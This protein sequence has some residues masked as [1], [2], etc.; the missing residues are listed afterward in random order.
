MARHNLL[1]VDGDARNRRVLE[2]SLRKA[3]FSITPAESA[4]EALEFLEHA[5]PDL[6]ISDT[7]LPGDDGFAFCTR[8][9]DNDRWA[10]IPF[11]FLTSGKAIEDKVRGLELGVDDYLTK[12]IYIKEITTRVA[13]LLQRKQRERLER[14]DARTKFSGQLADM[15]VVDLLQTLEISRKSGTIRLSTDLGDATLWFTDGAVIDAEMGR[16]QG[17][18]AVYR[19]LGI[20]DGLFEVEFKA[21]N[22]SQVIT[23]STQALLME[24]MRRVDEWSRLL[25]Q[26][27]PLETALTVDSEQIGERSGVESVDSEQLRFLR[28]FDGRRS[29]LEVVDESGQDDIEAL[30]TISQFFFEGVLALTSGVSRDKTPSPS[31]AASLKL[32]AWAAPVRLSGAEVPPPAEPETPPEDASESATPE[33]PPPPSY[34]A[35]FPQLD[36]EPAAEQ[37][38][39]V[40]GIPEDS[41]P[42]PAFGNSLV[43]LSEEESGPVVE[44]LSQRLDQIERGEKDVFNGPPPDGD[45]ADD[46]ADDLTDKEQDGDAPPLDASKLEAPS[47]L[48]D[49]RAAP[50]PP[51][52]DALDDLDKTKPDIPAPPLGRFALHPTPIKSPDSPQ[53]PHPRPTAVVMPSGDGPTVPSDSATP[54][55]VTKPT[56]I[57]AAVDDPEAGAIAP[58]HT[59]AGAIAPQ[60]TP[61]ADTDRLDL[62]PATEDGAESATETANESGSDH[63]AETDNESSAE[64]SATDTSSEPGDGATAGDDEPSRA[65]EDGELTVSPA[66][67]SDA[68]AQSWPGDRSVTL[69][70]TN[71][72]LSPPTGVLRASVHGSYDCNSE[73]DAG[74]ETPPRYL[75]DMSNPGE[76]GLEGR[77]NAELGLPTNLEDERPTLELEVRQDGEQV[78]LSPAPRDDDPNR[79]GRDAPEAVA[80]I[81]EPG[82][83]VR[84]D[85]PAADESGMW[86]HPRAPWEY[87]EYPGSEDASANQQSSSFYA[88]AA[89]VIVVVAAAGFAYGLLAPAPGA[90]ENPERLAADAGETLGQPSIVDQGAPGT[91]RIVEGAVSPDLGS[92]EDEAAAEET[93]GASATSSAG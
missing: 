22:R 44:A 77:L 72:Q 55:E 28:Y 26:L 56:D 23:A 38:S 49:R 61:P 45:D 50:G 84:D 24:G 82:I 73:T 78:V 68:A 70:A 86:R 11:I 41:S 47:P 43:S 18:P 92:G 4:E 5:G 17:E 79:E 13:M 3:G 29:I 74:P 58:L 7:R 76:Y 46:A 2:V 91:G 48:I 35:P 30:T 10:A 1:I 36:A 16:L 83:D 60:E 64:E 66:P 75:G 32:E 90:N 69:L 85:L 54:D 20:S 87:D 40:P 89:A 52:V 39:L 19:L 57:F 34:P 81:L 21:V 14:K 80:G 9:K 31:D 71:D 65:G 42:R 27:P 53:K 6:I 93:S 63:E 51:L 25:E 67:A 8:V 33:L 62:S 37:D 15:A 88:W 59:E 12:P